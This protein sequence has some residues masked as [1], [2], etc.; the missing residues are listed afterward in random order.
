MLVTVL[1][2]AIMYVLVVFCLR[3]MGKRQIAE[4]E[5]SELVVTI[6]I[7]EIAA[8]PVVDPGTPF[9]TAVVSIVILLF[10]EVFL[11]FIAYKNIN[12][13]SLLYGKPSTFFSDGKINQK[14]MQNQRYSI[15]DLLEEIRNQGATSLNDVEYV[16]METNGNVSVIQN[17]ISRPV[18]PSDL[19]LDVQPTEISYIIIDNG[20]LIKSNL[21]RL[22]LS[23]NWLMDELKK[24]GVKKISQVFYMGADKSGNAVV[25]KKEK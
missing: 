9:L 2:T 7:S 15:G 21:I 19:G 25:I 23:K 18:T 22:N 12:I 24:E 13:R 20:N 1:R 6:I 14:E 8:D 16:I 4:L 17:S 5:P 3:V 11:S 10:L